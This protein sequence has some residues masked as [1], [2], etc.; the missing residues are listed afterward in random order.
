MR[1]ITSLADLHDLPQWVVFAQVPQPDGSKPKKM[2]YTPGTNT[3]AKVNDPATWRTHAEALADAER[4]GRHPGIAL[5]PAMGVTLVDVDDRID[6]ALIAEV[7]SY[8]ERSLNGGLHIVCR[9][10]PP[11]HFI[12]PPGVEIY[13]R[14][15]NR[16]L[17]VTGDIIDGRGTIEERTELL[18]ELFP[19]AERP[20]IALPSAA[21]AMEDDEILRR[22]RSTKNGPEFS[23]LFD[24]GDIS[25]YENDASRAD[26]A[27]CSM[28]AFW[29]TDPTQIGRIFGQSALTRSKW[30]R[31]RGYREST[32]GKALHRSEFYTPAL[33]AVAAEIRVAPP[34]S[35]AVADPCAGRILELERQLAEAQATISVQIATIATLRSVQ[36]S[37][38]R[39]VGNRALGPPRIVAAMLA[40]Q[41]AWRA[42]AETPPGEVS[43][44]PPAG[45]MRLGVAAGARLAGVSPKSAGAH[46]ATLT[47]QGI[48]RRKIE[49]RLVSA[50]PDTGELLTRPEWRSVHFVGPANATTLTPETAVAFASEV[51]SVTPMRAENRGGKRVSRCPDHPEAGVVREHID[52]CATCR[53][54]LGRDEAPLPPV[55]LDPLPA[56]RSAKF[57]DHRGVAEDVLI[58]RKSADHSAGAGER[59]AH[60]ADRGRDHSRRESPAK[61]A[62]HSRDLAR[63]RAAADLALREP[64][65]LSAAPDPW[66]TP[67]SPPLPGLF[68]PPDPARSRHFDVGD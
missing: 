28:I 2:P 56:E 67:E 16:F 33:R 49:T 55:A 10:R 26:L 15:G 22:A 25:V 34:T 37:S 24:R 68:A 9:G 14:H 62:D 1:P 7:D 13:P 54:E 3:V 8:A 12:A 5:T 51:A 31:R 45:M 46:F 58:R 61:F 23:A 40:T 47:A 65:W 44:P 19:P 43:D 17:L 60:V 59:G 53:R 50:D 39:I 11:E 29:T 21:L 57:A 18:E 27:L 30:E 41:F 36:S 38:A 48:I 4:T 63:A 35:Q 32:I 42:T 6:D 52:R 66:E 20:A 64:A